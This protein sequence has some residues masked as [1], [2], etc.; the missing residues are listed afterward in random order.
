LKPRKQITDGI[1]EQNEAA[2][3]ASGCNGDPGLEMYIIKSGALKIYRQDDGREIILG[4]QFPG[5]TNGELELLHQDNRRL[6]SVAAIQP[7][8]MWVIR[9][10]ELEELMQVYPQ[11]MRKL[12]NVV[13]ERLQQANRKIEYLA[14]LDSRVRVA[15]LLLDLHANF[16]VP[17]DNGYLVN[18]KITQQHLANMIGIGRESATRALLEF[19][20]EKII[21]LKNR[22]ITILDLQGI[23]DRAGL[24][25]HYSLD[26]RKWHS[27]YRYDT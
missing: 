13:S 8:S 26:S 17:M 21:T 5:E 12:F 24:N 25:Q 14:F 7:T 22:M 4:H 27:T 15:N 20:D 2:D 16:S 11:I 10:P 6:A 3:Q 19:Q 23:Q 1:A 18:W 9:K